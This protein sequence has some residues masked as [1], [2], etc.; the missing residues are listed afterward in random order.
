MWAL[1][2][3]SGNDSGI[4]TAVNLDQDRAELTVFSI[5]EA[6]HL[7]CRL[8]KKQPCFDWRDNVRKCLS[9]IRAFQ[10]WHTRYNVKDVWIMFQQ[11]CIRFCTYSLF[12]SDHN[13]SGGDVEFQFVMH[14]HKKITPLYGPLAITS[15]I[16]SSVSGRE[17]CH[18]QTYSSH[19]YCSPVDF[20]FSC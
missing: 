7:N 13:H 8:W 14:S 3:H 1:Y 5:N 16:L 4:K 10:G 12:D 18:S 9:S 15:H 19:I 2:H 11:W 17:P 20:S 6:E